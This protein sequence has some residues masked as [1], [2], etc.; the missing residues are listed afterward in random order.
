[1]YV[2]L[3]NERWL[4]HGFWATETFVTNGDDLTIGKLVAFFE[5]AAW[6]GGSHLL[7]EVKGNI[8]KFFFD[9]TDNFTFGCRGE[10]DYKN[11]KLNNFYSKNE[12][13]PVVTNE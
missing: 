2:K 10:L 1:M 11:R 4:E 9:V 12:F 13:L 6:G 7:F 3:T 8:A 5:W